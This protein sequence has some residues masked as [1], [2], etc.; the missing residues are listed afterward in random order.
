MKKVKK[1]QKDILYGIFFLI[2]GLATLIPYNNVL[3]PSL[4]GYDSLCPFSPMSTAM[5]WGF[6]GFLL[7]QPIKRRNRKPWNSFAYIFSI[8]L[9]FYSIVHSGYLGMIGLL[10]WESRDCPPLVL[11]NLAD[12]VYV[13]ESNNI[14]KKVIMQVEIKDKKILSLKTIS[15]GHA[16]PFGQEAF[17][18]L[19]GRILK[20][21]KMEVD[22]VTG[23]THSCK[24]IVSAI[25][26]ALQSPLRQE[27]SKKERFGRKFQAVNTILRRA[28]SR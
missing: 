10:S 27:E 9:F 28:N 21:Q 24:Q 19:P 14:G 23:A 3:H 15:M 12:G 25:Y 8:I 5:L 22:A 16:S 2:S 6:A 26:N 18:H 13:G 1:K 4:L 20:A 17:R 11:E 7:L